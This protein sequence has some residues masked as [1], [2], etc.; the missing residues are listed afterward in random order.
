M[1]LLIGKKYWLPMEGP[2]EVVSIDD[3][4][5]RVKL[6]TKRERVIVTYKNSPQEREV[7]FNSGR[8]IVDISPNSE[9]TMID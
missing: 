6:L 7:R 4:R 5:A 3:Y 1:M 8:R 2:C 9:L